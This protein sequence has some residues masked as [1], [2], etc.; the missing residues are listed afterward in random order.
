M[1]AENRT[2]LQKLLNTGALSAQQAVLCEKYVELIEAWNQRTRLVSHNDE[3]RIVSRHITDS[4][5]FCRP[6]IIPYTGTI[7]DLGSG[8]GFPGI[9][10][11]LMAPHLRV[12]LVESR[13]MKALFLDEVIEQLEWSGIEVLCRR[14]ETLR[15]GDEV[16][17]LDRIVARCVAPLPQLWSWSRPLLKKGGL[18]AAQKG[19]NISRELSDSGAGSVSAVPLREDVKIYLLQAK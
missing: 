12:Y 15:S 7:L 11:K 9:V 5:G 18:L 17:P 10:I 19:G 2:A 16:P 14:V 1:R 6:E 4:L 13:R 3:S 8:A